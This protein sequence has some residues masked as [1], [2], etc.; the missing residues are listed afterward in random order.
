MEISEAHTFQ[1]VGRKGD[2]LPEERDLT[3]FP[4][5]AHLPMQKKNMKR[6]QMQER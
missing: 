2:R 6:E 1:K 3:E 5:H 4:E